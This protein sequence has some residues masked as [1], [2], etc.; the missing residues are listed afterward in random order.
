MA[1]RIRLRRDTAAN[2]TTANPVLQLAEAGW[3]TDSGKLKLGDGTK[4]WSALSYA[5]RSFIWKGTYV[6]ATAYKTMDCVSYLGASYICIA[7]STGNVPAVGTYWDLLSAKGDNG[8]NGTNG[9]DGTTFSWRGPYSNTTAYL[10][11]QAV[12]Y[13]GT[14]YMCISNTTAGQNPTNAVKWD[15]LA[16]KGTAGGNGTDGKSLN[17][18]GTW[19]TGVVYAPFDAVTKDGASY[20]CILASTSNTP[21]NATYWGILA[22][23]GSDGTPGSN[24]TPGT[25]GNNGTS[26][27]WKGA[28]VNGTAYVVGDG[29]SYGNSSYMCKANSSGNIPTNTSF[30]DLLALKGTDGTNGGAGAS[31]TSFIWKGAYNALTAYV[32][33]DVVS[34]GGSSYICISGT[35]GNEPTTI[36]KWSLVAQKG[37][38][39]TGG[40]TGFNAT[41]STYWASTSGQTVFDTINGYTDNN[42]DNYL[43]SVGAQDQIPNVNYTITAGTGGGRLTLESAPPT[44][45][46]V[47]IRALIAGTGGTGGTGSSLYDPAITDGTISTAIGGA[48]AQDAQVWRTKT[49]SEVFDLIL[50]PTSF[51]TYSVPTL[52]LSGT[53]SGYYEIGSSQSQV[54]TLVGTENDAG[55]FSALSLKKGGAN[56]SSTSSPTS[57]VTTSIPDQFGYAN[58][59][60]PNYTYT[61]EYTDSIT[62]TSGATTWSGGG[63]YSVG[64]AKKDNKNTTDSR[65]FAVRSVNAP[66]LASS[67]L[68]SGSITVTGGYP[69]Y[70]GVSDTA[71]TKADIAALISSNDAS[72]NKVVASAAGSISITFNATAKYLWFAHE[73]SIANK[74]AWYNSTLNNGGMGAD[75][76][77][78]APVQQNFTSGQGNWSG[79]SFDVYISNNVTDTSGAYI[80]S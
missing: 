44:G 5:A 45:T 56:L 77:F 64:S 32:V 52:S 80:L 79:V 25:N 75:Q 61:F 28:Y 34:F 35:T 7:D 22:S 26:F 17:W 23:K 55:A 54:L 42:E 73:A 43:V 74:T 46:L 3:E 11:G 72:V 63:V 21:P 62:V 27:S 67:N 76:L 59:N 33:N 39:G 41:T 29:V 40:G 78:A 57:A 19:A 69:Y 16:E 58:P 68:S 30:W 6:G 36:A 48:P 66:Q 37:D 60:N 71:V 47:S 2:W 10:V 13:N 20:I 18:R 24:G 38:A 9:T 12:S 65:S 8:T 50:F 14:A 53:L 4:T 49:L 31:G 51:P 70:W 1:D 15:T